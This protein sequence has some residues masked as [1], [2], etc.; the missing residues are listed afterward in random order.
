LVHLHCGI[1]LL[2]QPFRVINVKC[3]KANNIKTEVR[4]MKLYAKG[5]DNDYY[6]KDVGIVP[7]AK[8]NKLRRSL[9]RQLAKARRQEN[10]NICNYAEGK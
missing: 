10:R 9:K 2:F 5:C 3:R 1:N 4:K 8:E 7:N 6:H